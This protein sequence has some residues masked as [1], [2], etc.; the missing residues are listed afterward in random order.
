[1][2]EINFFHYSGHMDADLKAL[3]KKLTGLIALCTELRTE[4]ARLR[5][6]LNASVSEA[7]A[8]KANMAKASDRIEALM[9]TLP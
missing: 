7:T 5:Q 3:E 9:E 2:T 8:L 6:D 1:M 4:N